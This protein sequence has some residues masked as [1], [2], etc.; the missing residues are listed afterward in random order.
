MKIIV[1]KNIPFVR[2]L[3]E[4]YA[5]VE[6]LAPELITRDAVADADALLVRTR[7]RCDASLLA[8]SRVRFVG[9]CTIGTDHINLPWC[10]ENGITVANA[11]GCNA[12]A[13]AQYVLASVARFVSRPL[14][15]LTIGIVGVGHVGS[16]VER[17]SR[18]LGMNVMVCD[19]PR[20]RAEGGDGWST[21][22]DI[23]E[24]ADIITF[25]TPLLREGTDAT[26]HLVDDAFLAST[27]RKPVI[28][29]AARGPVADT[30]ALVRALK[31][32]TVSHAVID[33]WEGE[34]AIPTDL[35]RLASV[36]TPHIAGYS[37]EGKVRATR[38]VL[39][40]LTERFAS[41]P[42][43]TPSGERLPGLPPITMDV[44]VPPDAPRQ[45]ALSDIL[46]SYDPAKDTSALRSAFA[47]RG[48]SAF[49]ELRNHYDLRAEVPALR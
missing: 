33:T 4:A 5:S 23:A 46:E 27:G 39:D 6:Y 41:E 28:V 18:F 24:K 36:A 22:A 7:T 29:N 38:M 14:E 2:G 21:L 12:P 37:R 16:I 40:A 43:V 11:P 42:F 13:V 45:V 3:L 44:P 47:E 19:P 10:A 8:G 49:E 1:E 20:Q 48:S 15:E 17:W 32:G 25:H 31:A 30:S 9:T 26:F 34:P 35:L